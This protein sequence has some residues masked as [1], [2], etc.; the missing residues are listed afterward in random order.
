M[1]HSWKKHF[2]Q[3]TWGF[4]IRYP[5]SFCVSFIH[6]CSTCRLAAICFYLKGFCHT[7]A[8]MLAFENKQ[9]GKSLAPEGLLWRWQKFQLQ[10]NDWK[11][12]AWFLLNITD[13]CRNKLWVFVLISLSMFPGTLQHHTYC[14]LHTH[15]QLRT[16]SLYLVIYLLINLLLTEQMPTIFTGSFNLSISAH[17]LLIIN[18]YLH[19]LIRRHA[20]SEFF[21]FFRWFY[22][23]GLV[24]HNNEY[25][26]KYRWFS[27]S[28][29]L[30]LLMLYCESFTLSMLGDLGS[31]LV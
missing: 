13:Y 27:C 17:F 12:F 2:Q 15:I 28:L 31:E 23:T 11:R 18:V 16:H 1:L 24:R 4:Y 10:R 14:S 25:S 9:A 21:F 29:E 6:T 5:L 19:Q 3:F 20:L 22:C 7:I 30:L 8:Q 26:S